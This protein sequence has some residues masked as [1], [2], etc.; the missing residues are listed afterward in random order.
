MR[1][2][3]PTDAPLIHEA[4]ISVSPSDEEAHELGY[5]LLQLAGR[6]RDAGLA[7]AL[8]WVYERGPCAGCRFKAV[9][10]LDDLNLLEEPMAGE[11][12]HDG[13]EEIRQF[14]RERRERKPQP[15]V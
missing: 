14:V 9:R 2:Y 15:D 5:A 7:D 10:Y 3:D 13:N 1:N 12:E 4:L 8:R 6:H 11:C